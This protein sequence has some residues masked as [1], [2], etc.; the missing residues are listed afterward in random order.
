MIVVAK[1]G[2]GNFT[3]IQEAVDAIP[4]VPGSSPSIVLVRS[5]EYREKV[6]IHRDYVRLIGE[7]PETTVLTWNACAKDLYEDGTEKTT[8]LS[9]TLMTTGRDIEVENLTVRNDAGDGREVG[10][11]VAVYAAGDRGVWRGCRFIAHQDTLFCGPVRLPDVLEDIGGRHGCAEA[12]ARV[13]GGPLTFSRQYF[14][15]CFIQGDVDFIFGCYRCWFERC[16]LFMNERGGFY[17][18]AN[19]NSA[20]PF[21]FVF[22]RCCLTGACAPGQGWLG[23]PWRKGAATLFLE[24]EMEEQVAPEGFCDWDTDRVV[25]G[26]CGE[27]R[28]VG[29]RADQDTRH[30]AQKRLTDEEALL[31]T[32]PQVLGGTDGWNPERRV[33]TW[34][35][36]GDSI[37]ADYPPD[38]APMTGWGQVLPAFLD[39]EAYVQNEAVCGRSSRSFTDEKRLEQIALCIRRGD[40]MLIGFGHN[41]EKAE[42]PARYTSPGGTF[43]EY[44]NGFIDTALERGAAPVLI[45][46]VVRRRFDPN[47][48][49]VSTHGDYPEAIRGLARKRG[50]PLVDLEK[51]TADLLLDMG[52]DGSEQI[53]CHVPAGH[54]N[55]PEGL[56]DNSHLHLTGAVR[57]ARLFLGLLRINP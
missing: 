11:A 22:H 8:F 48:I 26:R 28:T 24:C 38:K 45:T 25:T 31:V 1:D 18:A 50:I 52:P 36:C 13:Q 34:F 57:I 41:D 20:Q 9:A 29:I 33:P 12:H 42:D 2:S 49:P 51:A 30:P 27:W 39:G 43:P 53:Y 19:T 7:D 44:L 55:Y 46:P 14:E 4:E 54:P 37:M 35:L 23:R 17:T 32:L 10:Q 6:V 21:G 3:S 16:T 15:D 47:G 56:A 5:G 40:R